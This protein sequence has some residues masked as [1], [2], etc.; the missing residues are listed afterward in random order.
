[1]H[2]SCIR[3]DT[4]SSRKIWVRG[5]QRQNPQRPRCSYRAPHKTRRSFGSPAWHCRDRHTDVIDR[6]SDCR[7]Q[8]QNADQFFRTH[9][10]IPSPIR[11]PTPKGHC[12]NANGDF[13]RENDRRASETET[14]YAFGTF[15]HFSVNKTQSVWSC[16]DESE[17]LPAC[18]NKTQRV[19]RNGC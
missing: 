10:E 11:R 8:Y 4:M 13:R 1:M 2:A 16:A 12:V 9:A 17:K 7:Q 18:E 5:K 15:R 6:E 3:F 19:G 14:H